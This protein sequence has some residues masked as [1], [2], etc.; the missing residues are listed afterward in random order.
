MFGIGAGW[1]RE[2]TEIFGGDFDHRWTQTREA[3]E[4]MKELWTKDEAEFHG[5]YYD[6]PPIK[7]D[8]KP[9]QQPHPPVILGG[10]ARRVLH[11]V[12]TWGDGWLP[13][14]IT[15]Q[16]LEDSR[17]RLDELATARGRDPKSLTISVYGQAPDGQLVQDFLNAGADRVVVRPEHCDTEEEMAAQMERIAEAVIK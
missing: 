9:V 13:N 1:N 6:F 16:E 17:K 5:T 12:A 15:P 14:R 10:L 4:V 3:V 7:S 11:R 2:E 8:P